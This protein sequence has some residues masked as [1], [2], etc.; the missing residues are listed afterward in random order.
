MKSQQNISEEFNSMFPNECPSTSFILVD[1]RYWPVEQLETYHLPR[2]VQPIIEKIEAYLRLKG[3]SSKK[4]W[5]QGHLGSATLV[6]TSSNGQ[7]HEVVVTTPQMS[8]IVLFNSADSLTYWEIQEATGMTDADLK[9]CLWSL[10]SADATSVLTMKKNVES[11][12]ALTSKCSLAS[13]E[14]QEATYMTNVIQGPCSSA[15]VFA[16]EMSKILDK[17]FEDSIF[18]FNEQFSGHMDLSQKHEFKTGILFEVVDE[19]E[20]YHIDAAIVRIMKKEKYIDLSRLLVAVTN[21][22][23]PFFTTTS[24]AIEGRIEELI[25]KEYLEKD[26]G[27]SN[28]YR[29]I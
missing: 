9:P 10:I 26:P 5:W 1:S 19:A 6:V 29:Y 21:A 14:I 22:L 7:R 8:I 25:K 20:K 24:A 17:L 12:L 28:C 13:G 15:S 11:E 2:D 18:S 16:P 4:I 27:D 23:Q 3:Y